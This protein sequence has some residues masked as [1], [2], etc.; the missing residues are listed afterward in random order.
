MCRESD[1]L[2]GVETIYSG[3]RLLGHVEKNRLT[4]LGNVNICVLG[5][6]ICCHKLIFF[7]Q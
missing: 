4:S 7:N 2:V 5:I 6:L 3:N 1:L